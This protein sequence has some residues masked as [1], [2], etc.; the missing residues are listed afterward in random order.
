MY[1]YLIYSHSQ[2]SDACVSQ[3][4]VLQLACGVLQALESPTGK[5]WEKLTTIE[6][7]RLKDYNVTKSLHCASECTLYVFLFAGADDKCK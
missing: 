6:K 3:R 1:M 5:H 2:H 7:V 4:A